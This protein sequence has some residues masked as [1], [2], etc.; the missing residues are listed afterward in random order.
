ML[1]DRS[2]G[3]AFAVSITAHL[4]VMA[5]PGWQLAS[6][7]EE[8]EP[9][10][11]EGRLAPPPVAA[12]QAAPVEPPPRAKAKPRYQLHPRRER[13]AVAAA[14]VQPAAE[15]ETP[16]TVAANAAAGA[17]E[18]SAG[19]QTI[20]GAEQATPA[21]AD[22][23]TSFAPGHAEANLP[24]Q[25]RIRYDV[26]LGDK[27]FVAGRAVHTWQQDGSAYVLKSVTEAVG[28]AS[29]LRPVR[30]VQVSEGVITDGGLVPSAYRS[31][32]NDATEPAE[33]A[34]FDWQQMRVVLTSKRRQQEASLVSGA[35]DLLSIIYQLAM[36]PAPADSTEFMIA[37]GKSFN[38]YVFDLVGEEQVATRVGDLRTA[39]LKTRAGKG[40]QMTEVWLALDY[41]NLPVRVRFTDRKGDS[42]DMIA[43]EIEFAGVRLAEVAAPQSQLPFSH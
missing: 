19:S 34:Q 23:P 1:F 42:A 30:I 7:E 26:T 39:H 10:R 2:L 11:L 37:T 35:Q 43:A 6:S 24:Q 27:E 17:A 40:E 9:V 20:A 14:E 8:T 31:L 28:L 5:G 12:P 18:E 16:P 29:L 41:R 22:E 36:A 3:T 25:G 13:V 15:P 38:P 33:S 32:R 21:P 4:L